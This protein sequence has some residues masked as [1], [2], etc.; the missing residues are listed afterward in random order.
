MDQTASLPK[1]ATIESKPYSA[2][3]RS[4]LEAVSKGAFTYDDTQL[5]AIDACLDP[6]RRVVA[7]TGEAGT[8]K[9]SI[10]RDVHRLWTSRD[11]RVV[12]CAPTGKAAKRIKELT[13]I[14]A[15]T[16]H[17]LLEYP[18]P[19]E[20][21]EKTGK[22]LIATEPKRDR[23]NPIS[24]DV[25]LCDE[26]AMVHAEL[27]R[28]LLDALPSGCLI[29]MFGDANQLQPI[30]SNEAY[31]KE[32]SPFNKML[33]KFD[34]HW[35]R[36]IH[37]Q[38][39]GSSIIQAGHRIIQGIMPARTEDFRFKITE[40]PVQATTDFIMDCL[41]DGTDFGG[42]DNQIITP[43]NKGWIG[44]IALNGTIQA[45]LQPSHKAH[46][47]LERHK[48]NENQILRVFEGDKVIWTQNCYPLELFNGETGIVK[49]FSELGEVVIDF[50][51]RTVAIPNVLE[52]EGRNGTYY[53]NPQRDIE[54]AYVITTHKAQGSEYE[55]VCYVMNRSRAYL[56]N[57]KNFY[58]AISRAR[59]RVMVITDQ[60][61]LN[62][63]LYKR[64][65][66]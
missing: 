48:W 53:I 47:E 39:E 51:D 44:T 32:A 9:T 40:E 59:K 25:V 43:V 57:R 20:R 54:L 26:Y 29:R 3:K 27:H 12:L 33:D 50:G 10:L 8:G 63:S 6:K 41:E 18:R 37:R 65:D 64:G 36:T 22:P 34:G 46:A 28:N 17:R 19:G 7:V 35:L 1:P 23:Q 4:D 5:R 45:L 31:K 30:E 24:Y 62:L 49:A 61:A 14:D 66:K 60:K 42:L 13:G 21:D 11:R 52:M 38:A 58:T 2:L 15:Q 56:L 55:K 16:V